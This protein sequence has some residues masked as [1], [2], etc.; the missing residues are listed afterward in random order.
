MVQG[1][2]TLSG[3][4]D[5]PSSIP[6]MHPV[7]REKKSHHLS[8][9]HH[10]MSESVY[11]HANKYR[12]VRKM[13]TFK[14]LLAVFGHSPQTQG[15]SCTEKNKSLSFKHSLTKNYPTRLNQ[16]PKLP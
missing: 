14:I 2:N 13:K 11:V 7:E 12:N 9:G 10:A 3:D 1:A 4:R 15:N 8:Q 6:R 16:L 5:D